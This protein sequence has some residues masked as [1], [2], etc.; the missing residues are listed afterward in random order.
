MENPVHQ[1]KIGDDKILTL[2]VDADNPVDNEFIEAFHKAAKT[3]PST[4]QEF[5]ITLNELHQKESQ[6]GK[7]I[8]SIK[9]CKDLRPAFQKKLLLFRL[10]CI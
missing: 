4:L 9:K 8:H 6:Q 7:N 10:T 1:A 5:F 3:Q 2:Q